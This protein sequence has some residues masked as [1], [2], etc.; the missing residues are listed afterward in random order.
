MT[1]KQQNGLCC[2]HSLRSPRIDPHVHQFS[3]FV[4]CFCF[5]CSCAI[6]GDAL[7]GGRDGTLDSGLSPTA[8]LLPRDSRQDS[9]HFLPVKPRGLVVPA[10]G[11]QVRMRRLE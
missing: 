10:L 4:G 11:A 9:H 3:L 7:H 8:Y 6:L 1:L 5:V 2:H